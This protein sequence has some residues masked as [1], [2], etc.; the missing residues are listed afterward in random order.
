MTLPPVD[1][2]RHADGFGIV[3]GAREA[4]FPPTRKGCRREVFLLRPSRMVMNGD[5]RAA[6]W[7]RKRLVCR[8]LKGWFSPRGRQRRQSPPEPRRGRG[9]EGSPGRNGAAATP[10]K[11]GRGR[12][13]RGLGAG[14]AENSGAERSPGAGR[15]P[16]CIISLEY[17]VLVWAK[18]DGYHSIPAYTVGMVN[19]W[20]IPVFAEYADPS[21]LAGAAAR[22]TWTDL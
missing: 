7:R 21:A 4:V 9:R 17:P 13:Q 10:G 2:L 6:Y 11:R 19:T 20:Y 8:T 15:V 3:F 1:V 5:V 12:A 18:R 22:V 16:C 14:R